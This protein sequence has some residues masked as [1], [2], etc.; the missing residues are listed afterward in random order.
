MADALLAFALTPASAAAVDRYVDAETGAGS[1]TACPQANPCDTI[2][3]VLENSGT[4]D[5]IL[6]DNGC[7]PEAVTVGDGRSL[8][9][10]NFVA[11]DGTGPAI[12][13]GGAGTAS[14]WAPRAGH[15]GGIDVRGRPPAMS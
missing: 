8:A 3:Y 6:I 11:G 15:V 9:F 13:D 12:V 5:E 7:Y 10:Q 4:G 2:A 1:N 14:R